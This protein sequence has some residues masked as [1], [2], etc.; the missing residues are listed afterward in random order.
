MYIRKTYLKRL[1]RWKDKPLIKIITGLRRSGKSTLIKLFVDSLVNSGV[2]PERVLYINKESLKFQHIAT[3]A[4]L[5]REALAAYQKVKHKLYLFVDEVQEID[6]WE[7][8]VVSLHSEEIADIYLTGSNARLFAGELATLLGGRYIQI[9]VFPLTYSEFLI[10]RQKDNHDEN[11]FNEFLQFGGLPGIHHLEWNEGVIYEYLNAVFDTIILRDIIKRNNIRNPA[12]LEK[13]VQFVFD[14]IAQIFSARRVVDFLK[15]EQRR[16]NVETV[17]NYL[18][19]L[20][21][22][23][24]VY[25]VPRYDIKGKRLLEVREKYFVADIGLRHALL[26][27]RAQDINQLLENIVFIELRKRGYRVFVGQLNDSEV[28]FIVEKEGQKAYLQI[29]YLLASQETIRRE[30]G[31]LMK[32][33]DNYPKYVLSLDR[34]FLPDREGIKQLNII[35]FL[36]AEDFVL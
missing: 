9:P 4:H 31:P 29:A 27:Y 15:K 5:Y 12:F 33:K 2:E 10:F 13:I 26:G 19:Y 11:A 22:A 8:A 24:M 16:T 32:I 17:Y 3:F 21:D 1:Y 36:L 7:K 6:Q 30:F 18:N 25:R 14:N 20:T 23:H 35:D 28:D 34:H